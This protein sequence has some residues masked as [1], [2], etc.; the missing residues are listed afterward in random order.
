MI[1]PQEN[2]DAAFKGINATIGLSLGYIKIFLKNKSCFPWFAQCIRTWNAPSPPVVHSAAMFSNFRRT[3]LHSDSFRCNSSGTTTATKVARFSQ[4]LVIVREIAYRRGTI[5]TTTPSFCPIFRTAQSDLPCR[6]FSV[7][8]NSDGR[9]SVELIATLWLW[10]W[11]WTTA[12]SRFLIVGRSTSKNIITLSRPA[13]KW[14]SPVGQRTGGTKATATRK[15]FANLFAGKVVKLGKRFSGR[16]AH[17][18]AK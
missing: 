18:F 4:N 12:T 7:R 16:T 6:R 11:R 10:L 13:V 15:P 2:A 9:E 14:G 17:P 8:E 5:A 1:L 3:A